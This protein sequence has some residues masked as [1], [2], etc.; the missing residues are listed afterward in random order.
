[1][2]QCI[3]NTII[4]TFDFE[5]LTAP[6]VAKK[7]A[8]G[9]QDSPKPGGQPMTPADLSRFKSD[10]ERHMT[11]V[12]NEQRQLQAASMALVRVSAEKSTQ[13]F[14]FLCSL[15]QRIARKLKPVTNVVYFLL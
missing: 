13:S 2:K 15:S 8:M 3:T 14:F 11:Q 7:A 6:T 5:S 1:M 10:R 9:S 12:V 4:M